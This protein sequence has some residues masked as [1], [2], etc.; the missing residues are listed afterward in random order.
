MAASSPGA[1]DV[2][3]IPV[4][5]NLPFLLAMTQSPAMFPS[6]VLAD[7]VDQIV[8]EMLAVSTKI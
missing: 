7:V 5:A 1:V 8:S 2:A 6:A 4:P 3:K